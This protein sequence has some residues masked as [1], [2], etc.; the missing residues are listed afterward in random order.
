MRELSGFGTDNDGREPGESRG[1]A[2]EL[3]ARAKKSE[4]EFLFS[5]G[6]FRQ[7]ADTAAGST[8]LTDEERAGFVRRAYD[9]LMAEQS[10]LEAAMLA[11]KY[12]KL[13]FSENEVR[14]TGIRAYQEAKQG[15]LAPSEAQLIA[16]EIGLSPR[17][18]FD[19]RNP[20]EKQKK[21]SKNP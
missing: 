18:E 1:N 19:V 10:F 4:V 5:S 12:E 6:L 3:V 15:E 11:K 13:G 9:G 20:T 16:D 8:F 21:G 14:E 7:A 17:R 2:F